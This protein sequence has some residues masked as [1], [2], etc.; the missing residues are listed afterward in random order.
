MSSKDKAPLLDDA[1]DRAATALIG[2]DETADATSQPLM[3]GNGSAADASAASQF[4]IPMKKARV[5]AVEWK[6]EQ[7]AIYMFEGKD[8]SKFEHHPRTPEAVVAYHAV[9]STWLNTIDII[10]GIVLML[11]ALFEYPAVCDN[12][13]NINATAI[14]EIL[15]LLAAHIH[16]LFY[17]RWKGTHIFKERK[18]ILKILLSVELL[19]EAIVVLA[20]QKHH[21]RFMRAFRPIFIIDNKFATGIKRVLYEIIQSL[22]PVI[23]ILVLLITFITTFAVMGYYLFGTQRTDTYTNDSH[24]WYFY[25]FQ[26]SWVNL[27]ILL[28]TANYPDVMMPAYRDSKWAA[29]FF[30][31]YLIVTLYIVANLVLA[32][33]YSNFNTK[34]KEKF[35]RL[36]IHRRLGLR[37]AFEI[38]GGHE[39]G[40]LDYE[41]FQGIVNTYLPGKTQ[42]EIV[43]MFKAMDPKGIGGVDLENWFNFYE[44]ALYRW[45]EDH[46]N[47]TGLFCSVN[48]YPPTIMPFFVVLN[49]IVTHRFFEWFIDFC[50]VVNAAFLIAEAALTTDQDEGRHAISDYEQVFLTIYTIEAVMRICGIGFRAYFSKGFNVFDFII[51]AVSLLGQAVERRTIYVTILRPFRLFRLMKLRRSFN[52][53]LSAMFNI[54]PRLVRFVLALVCVYY[55]FSIIAMS[56]LAGDISTC[57]C[58]KYQGEYQCDGVLFQSGQDPRVFLDR[59]ASLTAVCNNTLGC[60]YKKCGGHYSSYYDRSNADGLYYLNNFD[61]IVSSYVV[62]FELMVVNNWHVTMQGAV[63]STPSQTVATRAFFII[64][65]LVAV[66]IVTNVVVAF[67]LDAFQ[68]LLPTL[69]ARDEKEEARLKRRLASTEA[70]ASAAFTASGSTDAED[71]SD[72][73]T[74]ELTKYVYILRTVA[75]NLED[76]KFVRK[77]KKK[78]SGSAE[79]RIVGTR[80]IQ[81]LDIYLLIFGD[82]IDQWKD[83]ESDLAS[84]QPRERLTTFVDSYPHD[85]AHAKALSGA[86][87]SMSMSA[88]DPAPAPAAVASSPRAASVYTAP[89]YI[90]MSETVSSADGTQMDE[91]AT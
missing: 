90:P 13:I 17:F 74:D 79:V 3:S 65:Y 18:L 57:G 55:F 9:N 46:D 61:N 76:Q 1:P 73:D 51:V 88:D 87:M 5:Q 67:I 36:F 40:M 15:C 60:T 69:K 59:N 75:E 42:F 19:I 41:T 78:N 48:L 34:E 83:K 56:S 16:T 20:R 26:D 38:V 62:L 6:Y 72:V 50:I 27:F 84:S 35:S 47:S 7:A 2:E 8:H 77:L 53:I 64:F 81:P 21:L 85:T 11:L 31:V 12:C 54:I 58:V 14:V 86:H 10:A 30:I 23:E 22:P 91:S 24:N 37:K 70:E 68:S 28:T 32:A 71:N 80:R 52:H 89:Q 66:V 45:K 39:A 82:D 49:K 25:S 63:S 33:V 4:N 43:C 44:V 29:I